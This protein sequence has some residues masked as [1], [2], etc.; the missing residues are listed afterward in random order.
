MQ[1]MIAS[2]PKMLTHV[3]TSIK[4]RSVPRNGDSPV[5]HNALAKMLNHVN[6]SIKTRSV[7]RNGD[8]P[9]SHNALGAPL[10]QSALRSN[11]MMSYSSTF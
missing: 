6:T 1:V 5:S 4:T 11:A 9:V 10:I 7:P 3:N 2:S 8:S